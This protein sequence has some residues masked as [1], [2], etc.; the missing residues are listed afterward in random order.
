MRPESTHLEESTAA[1]S[2]YTQDTTDIEAIGV[3][4]N[5]QRTRLTSIPGHQP[6]VVDGRVAMN[7]Y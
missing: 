2:R 7:N 4:T 5:H 1:A 3:T 6:G